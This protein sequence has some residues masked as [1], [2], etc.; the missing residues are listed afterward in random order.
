MLGHLRMSLQSLGN[1]LL[2][3]AFDIM[4]VSSNFLTHPCIL[5]THMKLF[6]WSLLMGMCCFWKE[7]PGMNQTLIYLFIFEALL[8]FAYLVFW[9]DFFLDLRLMSVMW[10]CRRDSRKAVYLQHGVLDSSMGW[11]SCFYFL[12]FHHLWILIFVRLGKRKMGT[13]LCFFFLVGGGIERSSNFV[14]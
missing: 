9:L 11:V 10:Y 6:V 5:G 14:N 13:V 7:F 4:H 1:A 2:S 12:F 3:F 8:W